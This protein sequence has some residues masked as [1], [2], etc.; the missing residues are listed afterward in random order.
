MMP[1]EHK[2]G[3]CHLRC[4]AIWTLM[5]DQGSSRHRGDGR[6]VAARRRRSDIVSCSASSP[7][8]VRDVA[9]GGNPNCQAKVLHVR[10]S[11]IVNVH[12][13]VLIHAAGIDWDAASEKSQDDVTLPLDP[14]P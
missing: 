1:S 12:R 2:S 14:H 9:T 13:S 3:R 5:D 10:R 7:R 6:A 8:R 11:Q 4:D